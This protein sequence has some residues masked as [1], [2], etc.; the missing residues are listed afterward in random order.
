M[1]NFENYLLQELHSDKVVVLSEQ[2]FVKN[3]EFDSNKIYVVVKYFA[4]TIEFGAEIR[5]VQ[6]LVLSE[7]NGV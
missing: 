4:S 1:F 2:M 5:P 6:I 3:G 7:Q